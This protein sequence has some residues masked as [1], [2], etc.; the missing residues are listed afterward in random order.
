M[1]DQPALA[2]SYGRIGEQLHKIGG[3]EAGGN[4]WQSS[5]NVDSQTTCVVSSLLDRVLALLQLGLYSTCRPIHWLFQI[6]AFSEDVNGV[7]TDVHCT[8][9]CLYFGLFSENPE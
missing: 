2:I 4:E 6:H 3:E 1:G 7:V 8:S 9:P 5:H